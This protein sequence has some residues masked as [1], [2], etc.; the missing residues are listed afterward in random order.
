MLTYFGLIAVASL[1]I[2]VEFVWAIQTVMT[3][4]RALT[5]A[6]AE[7]EHIGPLVLKVLGALRN[8]AFMM[9]VVQVAVTLIVLIMLIR[10]ITGPLQ[11]M[12]EQAK[13]ICEGDLSRTIEIR[14]KDEIGLLGETINGLTSNI[15]EIV[16]LGLAADSAVRSPLDQLRTYVGNHP[17]CSEQL[18]KIEESVDAFRNILEGFKLLSAPLGEVEVDKEK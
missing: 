11:Q 6:S 1:L 13:A 7:A 18:D 14:R 16:A 15:Q 10:R 9:C 12:V 5:H 17:E 4:A 3:E 8:K 2:T